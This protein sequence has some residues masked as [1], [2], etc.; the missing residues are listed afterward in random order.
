M[1]C[2]GE[3]S[4]RSCICSELGDYSRSLP[5]GSDC[6]S[7]PIWGGSRGQ[8]ALRLGEDIEALQASMPK[9]M[10]RLK[11]V[12]VLATGKLC[13]LNAAMEPPVLNT[14]CAC[15]SPLEEREEVIADDNVSDCLRWCPLA[16]CCSLSYVHHARFCERLRESLLPVVLGRSGMWS[17]NW[18]LSVP[19]WV[20]Y[21]GPN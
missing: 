4:L 14:H 13:K 18:A 17:R 5:L 10:L 8:L 20:C 19:R 11:L 21:G 3:D 1:G 7:M 9:G 6:G 2:K 15:F 12:T 16:C